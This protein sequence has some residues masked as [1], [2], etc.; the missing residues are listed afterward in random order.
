LS[1][2]SFEDAKHIERRESWVLF[3]PEYLFP[4]Q[5]QE[6][7]DFFCEWSFAMSENIPGRKLLVVDEACRYQTNNKITPDAW[8]FK[9]AEVSALP[10][11]H[12][13]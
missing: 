3:D 13:V 6:A 12:F 4:G 8:G 2:L 11:L 1:L 10:D 9:P 7:F 5:L